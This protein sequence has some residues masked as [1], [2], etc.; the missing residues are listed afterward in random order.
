MR[1][2]LV[3]SALEGRFRELSG[4]AASRLAPEKFA[5][6]EG[7][8]SEVRERLLT[9]SVADFNDSVPGT[10]AWMD[11][12]TDCLGSLRVLS[13]GRAL[14]MRPGSRA[15]LESFIES[16]TAGRNDPDERF[17][18]LAER[19]SCPLNFTLPSED[20][21]REHVLTRLMAQDRAR[22]ERETVDAV[23]ADDLLLRLN[24]VA[25]YASRASDLRFLD[26]LNYYYELLPT[27]WQPRGRHGWLLASYFALYA[28]ALAARIG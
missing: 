5:G 22:V 2:E 19:Y 12:D 20:A 4:G 16:L 3:A 25:L 9:A 17:R 13:L 28:R 7:F 8:V 10:D 14:R 18:L 11:A 23:N 1:R 15:P 21:A 26:A 24:L 6:A 27:G